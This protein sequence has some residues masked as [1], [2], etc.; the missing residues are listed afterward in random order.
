MDRVFV[1]VPGFDCDLLVNL[2]HSM[3]FCRTGGHGHFGGK[4][5]RYFLGGAKPLRK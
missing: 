5:K 4:G 2:S 1:F 3:S